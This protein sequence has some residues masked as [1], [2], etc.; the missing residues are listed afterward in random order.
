MTV[1]QAQRA[2]VRASTGSDGARAQLARFLQ[3]MQPSRVGPRLDAV[4]KGQPTPIH[5]LDAKYEPGARAMLLYRRGAD[6]FVGALLPD[7]GG[8]G[9]G[10]VVP[11]GVQLWRFPIDPALP[12]LPR[13]MDHD[14]LGAALAEAVGRPS[15]SSTGRA[16]RSRTSLLR[17]RPGKRVT[18]LTALV[19]DRAKY[20][21][22]AYH[23]AEKAA[24][25]AAEGPR[26]TAAAIGSDTLALAP[27][28]THIADLRVVVQQAV[29]GVPLDILTGCA[30]WPTAAAAVAASAR[31]LAEFHQLAVVTGRERPV[32]GELSRFRARAT[33]IGGVDHHVG[34]ALEALAD[35]LLTQHGE[36]PAPWVGLVHGDCKPGQFLVAGRIHLVDLDHVG[37]SDQAVDVGTF[38]ASLHQRDIRRRPGRRCLEPSA[39][40]VA[41]S[42]SF[43][44]AYRDVRGPILD[45]ARI[46][47]HVAAALERKALRAF[48]R[49]PA[50]P[51][52]LALAAEAN[53]CLD[54]LEGERRQW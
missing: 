6:L 1:D 39:A 24:V 19:G 9:P 50:S 31:A 47:W 27:R 25:V 18:L 32:A 15:Y 3:A 42:R 54:G 45:P 30:S 7:E 33:A 38:L 46:R 52:P 17:F 13:V 11:P 22:K 2:D 53:R 40:V 36:L 23:D 48:A 5:V 20:V 26:L 21:V 10:C 34:D 4:V 41:L 43:L 44:N 28:V 12:T 8:Q 16:A 14:V 29:S 51:L 35:R 37:V 49:A